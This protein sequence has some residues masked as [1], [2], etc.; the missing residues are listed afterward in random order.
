MRSV[1]LRKLP[2]LAAALLVGAG[3]SLVNAF[4]SLRMMEVADHAIAGRK[5]DVFSSGIILIELALI[6]LV[7][8]SILT[9]AK[10]LYRRNTNI[11]LKRKYLSGVFSKNINEFNKD[12]TTV[13]V[14]GITNDLNTIDVN[15]V[16]A[17]FEFALSLI[18]FIVTVVVIA[19]VNLIVLIVIAGLAG[20]ISLIS[21]LMSKPLKRMVAERSVL[22][23]GYTS[24]LSEVLNAFRIIKSNDL[25]ARVKK[26]FHLRGEKLQSKSY[27]IDKFSTYIYAVQNGTIHFLVFGIL[28][29]S[30]YLVIRGQLTFGGIILIMTNLNFLLGPFERAGELLPK[31]LSSKTVFDSLDRSLQNEMQ[32][33]ETVEFGGFRDSIVLRDVCFAY[34][35]RKVLDNVGFSIRKGGKYLVVGPSG[36]G[37]STF[38]K[39]LRKY[40]YPQSGDVLVDGVPLK[41]ITKE[42]Y[43]RFIGNV[44]QNVFIFDDT[45]LNNLTLYRECSA[46]RI[47]SAIRKAGLQAFVDGLPSGLDTVIKDNGRNISGGEKSRI[48]IARAILEDVDILM[49]DEAFANLDY[50]TAM[51]IESTI[52]DADGLTVI[53]VSHLRISENMDKY[54]EVLKLGTGVS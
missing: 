17:I 38:L 7:L 28:V 48:A 46:T 49:L 34:D 1:V 35:E 13:Y 32:Y 2:L 50:R 6:L 4:M 16:D 43:F 44:D 47:S 45:L 22:Y 8:S 53:N 26:N 41:D 39:I 15:Y 37:K 5:D 33:E 54:D 23:E 24:Y 3:A 25:S 18:S 52:L 20:V 29:F 27:D 10:G 19:R 42:S 21:F 31:I 14:S 40:H 36:G 9:F 51:E 12:R 30:A 11:A